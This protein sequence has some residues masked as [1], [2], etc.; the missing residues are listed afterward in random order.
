MLNEHDLNTWREE[1]ITPEQAKNALD[2]LNDEVGSWVEHYAILEEFIKQYHDL[3]KVKTLP[4]I[5]KP[6]KGE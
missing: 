1:M 5:L 3:L 2:N 4:Y 6:K